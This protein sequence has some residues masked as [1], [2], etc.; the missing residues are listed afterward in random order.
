MVKEFSHG[1]MEL[2]TK[3]NS[4]IMRSQDKE[5]TNFQMDQN[6]KVRLKMEL[7]MDLANI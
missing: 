2:F 1:K 5:F 7:E 3:V 4:E 6:M